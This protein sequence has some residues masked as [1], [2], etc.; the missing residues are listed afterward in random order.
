MDGGVLLYFG[1][2]FLCFGGFSGIAMKDRPDINAATRIVA[3]QGR[4]PLF[5][6]VICIPTGLLII[7]AALF[8]KSPS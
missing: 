1:F 6:C 2:L 3:A 7:V 4:W 5:A 8:M